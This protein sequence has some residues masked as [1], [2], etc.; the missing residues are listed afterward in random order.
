MAY[1]LGV[2]VGT[3]F[4][5]AA[6]WRRHDGR[7]EVVALGERASVIPS[8]LFLR[9]DGE[10]L[11]GEAARRR[12][13]GEPQ[14]VA[15]ELKRRIGDTVPVL[16]DGRPFA[17][18]TL[19]G[20]L[21]AWV[22]AQVS[23]RED[24]PPERL[25]VTCPTN[26]GEYRRELLVQAARRAGLGEIMLLTEPVA[27]ATWYGSRERLEPGA[28]VGVYGLGGGTFDAAVLRK[29][30]AGFE[31]VGQPAGDDSLG[32]V[33]FDQTIVDHLT[34][35]LGSRLTELDPADPAVRGGL[36]Q[37]RANAVAAKETLSSDLEAEIPVHLPGVTGQVRLTRAELEERIRASLEPTI[38]TFR[39]MIASAQV[40]P[41]DLHTV[42]LVGG[43]SRIPLVS[44]LVA[45]AIGVPVVVDTHPKLAVCL[46]AAAAGALH[47]S[48]DAPPLRVEPPDTQPDPPAL[49]VPEAVP[50]WVT[51]GGTAALT[52]IIVPF[53]QALA[54][55]LADDVYAKLRPL[56][57][58]RPAE[59]V[60]A[61]LRVL[62]SGHPVVERGGVIIRD[63]D[64]GTVLVVPSHL[65]DEAI[66]Q[67]VRKGPKRIHGRILIWDDANQTWEFSGP[68]GRLRHQP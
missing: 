37:M 17:P 54:G 11:V 58:R 40:A 27:A 59:D 26:W 18:E 34:E 52:S 51:V 13:V 36:A 64:T 2:D 23:Q 24:G 45:D 66:K 53:V 14:R 32:G 5:A 39:Q 68:R 62:L 7:A 10:W 50:D 16:V 44:E 61:R 28:L 30:D 4:T 57:H 35:V 56:L 60:E 41:T 21:L 12:A 33:D 20:V 9:P 15:S 48:S 29:T 63:P 3:T 31:L 38:A 25:V 55:K 43:S 6:T 8:V 22:L 46:G 67:L 49:A 65:P 42:L 47:R 19:V 1:V